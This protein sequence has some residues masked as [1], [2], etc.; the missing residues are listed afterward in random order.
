V[1][2]VWQGFGINFHYCISL[3]ETKIYAL[4]RVFQCFGREFSNSTRKQA[5]NEVIMQKIT[6]RAA[7][8][9]GLDTY[10]TGK[11]CKYGHI[12]ERR[13]SD[14][15]CLECP[16]KAKKAKPKNEFNLFEKF[17]DFMNE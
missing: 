10:F 16:H 7:K 9:Q 8:M 5:I 6:R 1:A 2:R 11:L 17:E 12:S 4:I 13:V 14:Y 3:C 15:Q